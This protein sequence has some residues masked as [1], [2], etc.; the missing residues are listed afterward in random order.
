MSKSKIQAEK[1][2]EGIEKGETIDSLKTKLSNNK[3]EWHRYS[4]KAYSLNLENAKKDR[5]IQEKARNVICTST[6]QIKEILKVNKT[7]S[8]YAL[9][10]PI[11]CTLMEL[12]SIKNLIEKLPD[13]DAEKEI[14][15]IIGNMTTHPRL[16]MLQQKGRFEKLEHFTPFSKLLHAANISYYRENYISCYLTLIPIVE[17]IIIRW[18]GY[19]ESDEKPDF[20]TIRKFFQNSHTRQPYPHNILFHKIYCEVCNKILNSHLFKPT[21]TGNSFADFNRHVA[22]HLL[23]DNDFATKEN[24]IRLYILL[25]SMTEIFIYETRQTDPRFEL[26]NEDLEPELKIYSLLFLSQLDSNPENIILN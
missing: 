11:F 25:D 8:D 5:K 10:L 1:I 26:S 12:N 17:G 9:L 6:D 23:N 15:F 24:C 7:L 4:S 19:K 16:R 2:I 3:D 18:M 14:I 22:S 21:S 13:A 20:E